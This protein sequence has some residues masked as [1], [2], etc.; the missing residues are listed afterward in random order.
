MQECQNSVINWLP[1]WILI[2]L[3]IQVKLAANYEL[4]NNNMK[5]LLLLLLL[6]FCPPWLDNE[7]LYRPH[8]LSKSTLRSV[9]FKPM[10]FSAGHLSAPILHPINVPF[11]SPP[12]WGSLFNSYFSRHEV[13]VNINLFLRLSKH[14][15]RMTY[16]VV[17]AYFHA[18]LTSAL[19]GG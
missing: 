8:N 9:V 17:E 10:P 15:A 5:C 13:K 18:F 1:I 11:P 14:H 16:W 2:G 3:I 6:L 12:V 4:R 19:D 7:C